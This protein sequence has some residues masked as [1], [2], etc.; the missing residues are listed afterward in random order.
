M[1]RALTGLLLQA[2]LADADALH[3]YLW[4]SGCWPDILRTLECA[5]LVPLPARGNQMKHN[6]L[7]LEPELPHIKLAL[8]AGEQITSDQPCI[9]SGT[10]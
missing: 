9:L 10:Q 7:S 3:E 2:S 8:R 1:A 4:Q 5:V 6:G